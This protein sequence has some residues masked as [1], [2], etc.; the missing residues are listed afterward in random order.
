MKKLL[1]GAVGCAAL[2]L[3]AGISGCGGGDG[4]TGTGGD[5]ALVG[6]WRMTSMSVDGG[7]AFP[8]ATIGWDLLLILNADGSC[9]GTDLWRG[10]TDSSG[11]GWTVTGS[12]L[13]I[14]VGEY[15]WTGTYTAGAGSF[16]LAGVTDYD[17][18]GHTGAFVFTR[19]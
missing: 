14:A 8:P 16:Q 9:T 10:E 18:E 7:G 12:L 1:V 11:G 15:N 13:N 17:G 6:T 5:P 4:N 3:A 2:M 19:Q